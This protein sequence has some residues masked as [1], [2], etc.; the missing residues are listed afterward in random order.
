MDV[1][2]KIKSNNK[3]VKA[4]IGYT[5][6][7]YLLKGINFLT[8]PL[9]TR[10]M[11]TSDYGVFNIYGTYDSIISVFIALALHSCLNN[12]KY[13]YKENF[14]RFVSSILL[15]PIIV[16]SVLLVVANVFCSTF[17]RILDINRFL[18]NILLIHSFANSI[19]TIFNTKIGIDYQY[20]SFLKI[21]YINTISNI[22]LS[23]VLMQTLFTNEKYSG[24]IVGSALPMIV[25][26]VYIYVISFKKAKPRYDKE[27]WKFGVSYSLPIIPH[28]LSQI[29]LSSFDKIMIKSIVGVSEAGIYSLGGNIEQ[30]V[31]VTKTSLDMVWGPWFY[32]K[33]QKK[34]YSEIK[35]YSS[36]YAFFMFVFISCLMLA[37]PELVFIMGAPDYQDAKYV[38]VPLLNCTFFTFLY[39]LPST[40]EYYYQQTKMIA[41]GTVGAAI[42]NIVLNLLFIRLYGY[43]AAAYTTLTAYVIYFVFHYYIAKKIAKMQIFNTKVL[44]CLIVCIGL[45][46]A[47]S[48]IFIEN[49]FVRLFGGIIFMAICVGVTWKLIVPQIDVFRRK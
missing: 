4:G 31:Q 6:G 11:S 9:F 5:V 25:I 44:F 30:I 46:N 1:F 22:V 16:L 43:R 37:A 14:D 23:L 7:N 28:G 20:K 27:Y 36:F 3:V 47:F 8:V 17:V 12:A 48:V 26:A 2:R 45:I 10:I 21:S 35:K 40:V 42:L 15:I 33:M 13:K 38:V 18:I 24:R 41:L 19:I 34:D 29:V 32:E 49:F 39:T